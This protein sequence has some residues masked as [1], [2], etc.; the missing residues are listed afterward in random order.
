METYWLTLCERTGVQ[1]FLKSKG[2]PGDRFEDGARMTVSIQTPTSTSC[3]IVA[4]GDL[5]NSKTIG[6]VQ[7][8]I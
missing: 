8:C 1:T 5:A 3:G 6:G 4:W 2:D 7:N